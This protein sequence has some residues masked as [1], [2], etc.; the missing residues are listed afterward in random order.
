MSR[1][2]SSRNTDSE[3]CFTL[4]DPVL[5]FGLWNAS[6]DFESFHPE[7]SLDLRELRN[8][9]ERSKIVLTK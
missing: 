2:V 9:T 4:P 8:L 1:V 6:D 5:Y 7:C 3:V